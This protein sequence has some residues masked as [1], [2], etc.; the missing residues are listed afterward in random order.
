MF[1]LIGLETAIEWDRPQHARPDSERQLPTV[2]VDPGGIDHKTIKRRQPLQG[3]G[4]SLLPAPYPQ[5]RPQ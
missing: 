5:A 2:D 1:S 3:K 4:Y